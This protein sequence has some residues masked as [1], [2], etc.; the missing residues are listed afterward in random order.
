MWA[1]GKTAA[2]ARRGIGL[3][4]GVDHQH[5]EVGV[6]LRG[7]AGERLVE[8]VSGVVRHHDGHDGRDPCSH[9]VSRGGWGAVRRCCCIHDGPTL[10]LAM[11]S[12]GSSQAH[13]RR[14]SGSCDICHS[15][16]E[17]LAT[18]MQSA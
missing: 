18:V 13:L 10:P 17:V 11:G 2:I 9:L 8:P 6:G 12:P 16:R 4:R 5:G 1:S 7:K 3:A 14:I 15:A